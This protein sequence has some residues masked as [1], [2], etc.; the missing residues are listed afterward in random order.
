MSLEAVATLPWVEKYRPKT[1]DDVINQEEVITSLK[2]I[3]RTKA[4]PHML[5]SGPPGVGKTATAHAFARDLYGP[6]YIEDGWFVEINASVTPETPILIRE[7]G[8]IQRI[9][10][11][12]LAG[13]YFRDQYAH[14]ILL[15]N[16]PEIL[17]LDAELQVMFKPITAISRHKVN[18]VVKIEY[19]GGEVRTSLDHSVMVINTIDGRLVKKKASEIKLG[20]YLISFKALLPSSPPNRGIRS[21]IL[22]VEYITRV[23]N[24]ELNHAINSVVSQLKW[25]SDPNTGEGYAGSILLGGWRM[26]SPSLEKAQLT[27]PGSIGS[28]KKHLT[29]NSY[30]HTR[31]SLHNRARINSISMYFYGDNQIRFLGGAISYPSEKNR[32]NERIPMDVF[33]LNP[34]KR[35]D[36]M[37]EYLRDA[38]GRWGEALR[39]DSRS[40]E[41]LIDL[42]WLASI[43]GI[44]SSISQ[45]ECRLT[46]KSNKC[47]HI[48]SELLPSSIIS[49]L[50]AYIS[51]EKVWYQNRRRI[52]GGEGGKI[53]K[54]MIAEVLEK[55]DKGSLTV[56]GREGFDRLMG[57]V[58]SPLYLVKVTNIE[59][60]E[61]DGYVYDV[62]VPGSEVFWGGT[63]P[64][65]L[66]NSDER[67]IQT[68]REKV[69]MF[70]RQIPLGGEIGFK[71]LLLDESDQLT[72]DA[73]HAFRRV[74]EQY[75]STCRFILA[76][77]YT[78]RIIEPIQSRCAVFRF[79][80]L[81]KKDVINRVKWIAEQEKL[82]VDG[83]ALEAIYEFSEGDMRRAI[84]TLQAAASVSR[85]IDEK[86]V[87]YILGY[88]SRGEIRRILELAMGG[89]FT[90]ARDEL[91]KLIYVQGLAGSDIV[92]AIYRELFY[93]DLNEE[94]KLELLDLLGEV[95]YRMAEGGTEEVQL[96]A[97]L[98]RLTAKSRKK[99]KQ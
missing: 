5:F 13:R 85:K 24:K 34:H 98:A 3:L 87:Y 14:Y 30:I 50:L 99:T 9:T 36:F 65:L 47:P 44:E 21:Q 55:I 1:L 51:S 40:T 93:L 95:D 6:N 83:A 12:D 10:I 43:T 57:L 75:S 31:P 82:E 76:A 63:K 17:S 94:D 48:E 61:Y 53:P 80:P 60:E 11:G 68:I 23:A 29:G 27:A 8:L 20:E 2:N 33:N 54:K 39:Y 18:K 4:V 38:D 62:S 74:M 86:T 90:Q 25:L 71:I 46:W 81:L 32:V 16:G 69:K 91:R 73:Q 56:K 89:N 41:E 84:N 15:E 67:G 59:I 77:N 78:N 35:I 64:I 58:K 49:D 7:D 45:N 19:E 70:A 52:Y 22:K 92:S 79:R 28:P 26:P 96:M 37:K 72:D 97:F 88:V 66:H 42:V